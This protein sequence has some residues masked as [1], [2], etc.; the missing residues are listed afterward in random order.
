M[1][2]PKVIVVY[3]GE[4]P[5]CRNYCRRVRIQRNVGCLKLID[6]RLDSEIMQEIT[7]RGLDI[8]Q[9][10]V[11]KI[12]K[13][14]YYGSDALHVLSLLSSR[15]NLFNQI[16]FWLFCHPLITRV[17]YPV[18]RACRNLVLKTYGVSKINNLNNT[19]T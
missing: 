4:C 16:N 11:V 5:F 3:D 2:L 9:G 12:D 13:C 14:I 10:M 15:S 8:D 6:A 7:Q 1:S 17:L 18:L 19:V